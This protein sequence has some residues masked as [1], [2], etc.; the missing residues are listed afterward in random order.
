MTAKKKIVVFSGGSA[1]NNL[2]DVF[3]TLCGVRRSL[4]FVLPI[5]DNGGSTSEIL[6]IC[7]G[8]GIGDVRSGVLLFPLLSF[9]GSLW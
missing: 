4:D 6:R 3:K 2:I 8:P 9:F 7:G 1:A 5:S